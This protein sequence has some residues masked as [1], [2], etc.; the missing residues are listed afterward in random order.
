MKKKAL[1]LIAATA[2]A[3]SLSTGAQASSPFA[4]CA[5]TDNVQFDGT[6]VDAA[7][8]TPELSTLVDAVVAAGLADA[9]ATTE[10]ITVY[11]PTNDAFAAVP[12]DILNT[13][14]GNTDLLTAVLTYHVVPSKNDDPR[15]WLAPVKRTTLMGQD[16]F[17]TRSMGSPSVNNANVTCQG[18]S[19]SNGTVYV[20]DSVLLPNL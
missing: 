7:I 11:A 19:T 16:V 8:A 3:I 18:V 10:N 4:N 20:I 9:L 15:K 13:I 14:V 6:I 1:S 2:A 17:F 12:A 5:A